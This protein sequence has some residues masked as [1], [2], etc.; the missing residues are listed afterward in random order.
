MMRRL[1][2][3]MTTIVRRVDVS[4]RIGEPIPT[5][6]LTRGN[7]DELIARVRDRIRMLLGEGPVWT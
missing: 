2:A 6:G 7:R 4:V 3:G 5:A 1:S